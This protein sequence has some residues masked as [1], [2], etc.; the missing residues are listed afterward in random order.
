MHLNFNNQDVIPAINLSWK[1][2]REYQKKRS[3]N[4]G[5]IEMFSTNVSWFLIEAVTEIHFHLC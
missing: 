2:A 5:K 1:M 4:L 3:H